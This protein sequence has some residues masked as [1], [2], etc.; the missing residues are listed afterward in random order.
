M[1]VK[2]EIYEGELI[3]PNEGVDV[4]YRPSPLKLERK[5]AKATAGL[6]IA[7]V[8]K[9]CDIDIKKNLHVTLNGH[10]I[11]RKNWN[12]IRV[13]KGVSVNALVVPG[14][15][16]LRSV[17]SIVVA[18][19]AIAVAPILA[20]FLFPGLAAGSA[21]LATVTSIIGAGIT[22]AGSL[23][24]NALF[25]VSKPSTDSTLSETT[26]N[27]YSIGGAK[28]ESGTFQ[29]IPTV[30][31]THRISPPYAANPFTEIIGDDQYLRMLFC[32][33]YG[34]IAMSDIRIGE[35]PIG[36]FDGMQI[37][38][39]ENHISTPPTLY[40][41][42]VYEET[43]QI[44][45]KNSDGW[46]QRTTADNID[47]ISVDISFPNGIFRVQKSDGNRVNF[48]VNVAVQYAPTGTG[49]WATLGT[50]DITTNS[51]QAIRRSLYIDVPNGQYDVRVQKTSADYTGEDQVSEAVYWSAVRGRRNKSVI[52]FSKPLSIIAL[53]IKAT[54][55][56]NGVVDNLNLIAS[57]RIRAYNGS[58]WVDNQI[59]SNP[60][61]HFRAVLQSNANERPRTDSE[62]DLASIEDWWSFCNA[63]GFTFDYVAT[64]ARSVYETLT[65]IAAAGRAAVTLQDGKWGVVYDKADTP[66][67][68]H[69][70]PRNSWG[71]DSSRAYLDVPHGFRMSFINRNNNYLVDERIVY[72]DGFSAANATRF[73]GLD[74]P[75]IVDPDLVWRHGRYHLAQLRLQREVFTLNADFENLV[76]TRGDRVRVN[77][78]VT[79]WGL[80][81]AR[82]KSTTISPDTVTIDDTFTM[83]AGKTYAM[84]FRKENGDTLVRTI[85]GIDGE[86][87]TFTLDNSGELP[88][89]G[90]L[91]MFGEQSFE[92]VVLRVK[93]IT[94]QSDLTAKIELVNDAPEILEADQGTIPEFV[95]GIVPSIDYRT[96]S[97]RDIFYTEEI[98]EF[99]P[100]SSTLNL[101][102]LPPEGGETVG[103]IV[104]FRPT[105]TEDWTTR[106]TTT[107]YIAINGLATGVYDVRIRGINSTDALSQ[108]ATTTAVLDIF[109]RTPADVINFNI[110]VN[111]DIA[112]LQWTANTEQYVSHYQIRFSPD[113]SGVTWQTSSLLRDNVNV[114]QV[115]VP[116]L[117]GTYL[118]K[119][120][121]YSGIV[122]ENPTVIVNQINP[123]TSF[124]AVET[125]IEHPTFAG[126]KT[127]VVLLDNG[128]QLETQGDLFELTDWFEP[129]DYFLSGGGYPT[130]GIYDFFNSIDLGAVYTSRVSAS[131]KAFGYYSGG[132]VFSRIDWFAPPDFFG[133]ENNGLWDTK[134]EIST[135][136][137]DPAG[138]PTWSNWTELVTSDVYA[139][140]YRFRLRLISGQF[141]VTPVV[142]ELSVLIDMPDRVIAANDLVVPVTGLRVNFVPAYFSL[143]GLSIAAQDLDTGDYAEIT[144]KDKTGFDIIFKDSS[145]VAIERTFDYVAKGYG[146]EN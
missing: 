117:V 20:G 134:V 55:E 72:D 125:I 29:P 8:L 118:I 136:E 4:Y 108:W 98:W 61:D 115:P 105:G 38:A 77:H 146:V 27:L 59:T 67:V 140:A 24:I 89:N 99:V 9:A 18:I 83:E 47:S 124:N 76:C 5:H 48:T 78:D 42:P 33:G 3:A 91:V 85:T 123:L 37:E 127:D 54:N 137:D 126:N 28:N 62:I 96:L 7:E 57:S 139:R 97:P 103:Y 69:F 35:T 130:E 36:L 133:L 114:N 11:P 22:I 101:T 111:G 49:A 100:P 44:L 6:T 129:A 106:S 17:L 93:G 120:V 30:F 143:S 32:V 66:I 31:G 95:T 71:F 109:S 81:S 79:L 16:S 145:N 70:T 104:Q 132:D 15:G 19:V 52:N 138:T 80:G 50:I 74:F 131:V 45:L 141:D 46:S 88:Y 110:S 128:L 68:Q 2:H 43:V 25:P 107:P 58:S 84:R 86:F 41:Q 56:L 34:P 26:K 144:N 12:R 63:E 113:T 73:E 119:A 142:T 92:S 112:N 10:V 23:A 40:T 21:A 14:K 1:L 64:E 65:M 121:T 13:K 60:A 51:Q 53:R 116:A 94:A 90:A 135:T 39:I 87:S 82:V 122:S 102:W 75:G